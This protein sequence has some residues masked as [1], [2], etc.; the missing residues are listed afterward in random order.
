M[1]GVRI[2]LA[3][4]AEVDVEDAVLHR[5]Q[6]HEGVG[7]RLVG[8]ERVEGEA[9]PLAAGVD[10]LHAGR[11][12][13][14]VAHRRQRA[15]GDVLDRQAQTGR[16]AGAAAVGDGVEETRLVGRRPHL[17]PLAAHARR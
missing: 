14:H 3:A 17:G 2:A 10:L 16:G 12:G 13:E 5:R 7:A 1:P 11:E 9:D 6:D 4:V 15:P 8:L